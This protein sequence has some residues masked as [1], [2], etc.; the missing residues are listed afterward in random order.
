MYAVQSLERS[1]KEEQ[2]HTSLGEDDEEH[3][4]DEAALGRT[5]HASS[6]KYIRPQK[7]DRPHTRASISLRTAISEAC[8]HT[9]S[10]LAEYGT[11]TC[12]LQRVWEIVCNWKSP[13]S[14]FL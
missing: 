12:R 10:V 1:S 8:S 11:R 6:R 9:L 13:P 4:V 14:P 5:D 7:S 3:D 2:Q